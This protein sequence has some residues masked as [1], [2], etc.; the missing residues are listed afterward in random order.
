MK[1]FEVY[2]GIVNERQIEACVKNFGEELFSPQLGG[3]E[4]N[5]RLEDRYLELI[6]DFTD[7]AYG[8]ET[9]P[10]FIKALSNLK[11]C[12]EQ[13]PE[14]L[15]PK[16]TM[17]YRGT[18][19]HVSHFIDNRLTIETDREYSYVYKASSPIQ[20]WSTNAKASE[21]FGKHEIVNE[22]ARKIDFEDYTTPESRRDLLNLMVKEEMR[23]GFVL[24][25]MA[26]ENQ[27]IFNSEY[28]RVLSAMYAEEEVI[29]M[30]N[31]PINVTAKFNTNSQEAKL[32][33]D[34]FTLIKLVNQAITEL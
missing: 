25:Y 1:I 31:K 3:D 28:F 30:T 32:T 22:I 2:K 20:S 12:T 13:Y 19:I 18:T 9:N 10:D 4:P 5:T 27:F 15:T 26:N 29:R 21:N 34:G 16:D 8:E 14:I 6:H 33:S 23:I 17:A 24:S 7:N 11:R